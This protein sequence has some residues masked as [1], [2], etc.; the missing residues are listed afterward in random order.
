MLGKTNSPE[1][2]HLGATENRLGK[3]CWNPWNPERTSGGSSG[4]A[5]AAVAAGLCAVATGGD[6]G[7]SIRIPA[8]FCGTYGIKPTQGRVSSYPG[9][10]G[11]P[12]VNL[13]GQH[14]PISRTVADSAMLLQIMSEL[15]S[16]GY[17]IDASART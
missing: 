2:G 4:G 15:R 3:S 8:S 13:L 17:R 11:P 10:D 12:T 1:F 16:P 9:V 14:G 7:G 5:A 6:G